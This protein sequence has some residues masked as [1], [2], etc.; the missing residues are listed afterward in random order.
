MNAMLPVL[1]GDREDAGKMAR[2]HLGPGHAPFLQ[3]HVGALQTPA[4]LATGEVLGRNHGS[5]DLTHQ[6]DPPAI[7][8]VFNTYPALLA[9]CIPAWFALSCGEL[10]S[11]RLLSDGCADAN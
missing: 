3:E 4:K 10:K 9:S 6:D 5:P 7:C 1:C 8:S 2:N 11:V